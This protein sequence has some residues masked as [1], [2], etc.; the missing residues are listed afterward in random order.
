MSS[1]G[2]TTTIGAPRKNPEVGLSAQLG[3]EKLHNLETLFTLLHNYDIGLLY[4]DPQL[5]LRETELQ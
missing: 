4:P 1:C 5:S 3:R 2:P